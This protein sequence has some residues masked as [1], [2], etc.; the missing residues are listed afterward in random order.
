MPYSFRHYFITQRITAGLSYQQVSQMCGTSI[1]Q[2]ERTYYH[3]ND[4]VRMAH[5]LAG[6]E[7]D[8]DGMVVPVEGAED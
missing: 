1:T 3:L 4:E 6:Y 8:D 2:I 5:A 7:I